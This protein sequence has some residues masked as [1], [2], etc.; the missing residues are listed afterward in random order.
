MDLEKT[1]D[2]FKNNFLGRGVLWVLSQF[3]SLG[4]AL[5]KFLYT[6]HWRKTYSV[7]TRV[8]CI[9][10]ITAGGTG[11]TT[12]VLLAARTL[13]QAGI[14]TAIISRGYKRA[15][16]DKN[17]VVLFDDELENNWTTA[18]DEPFMMSRSLADVKVPI[19]IHKDRYLAATEALRRF[20]SQIILLDDGFQHFRLKRDVDIV[21]IDARNP[22]GD[23]RLLPYGTLRENLKGLSRANLILITH[24]D[25]VDARRLEDIRDQIR[26]INEDVQILS[27]VHKPDHYFDICESKKVPLTALKGEAGAFSAIGEPGG[28]EDTLRKLGLTL[29][30][31]WRY[32][33]HRR[34]T[35]FDLKNFMELSGGAPLITT[36]KDFVKF[37]DNWRDI[38]NKNVYVLSINMEIKG[39]KEFEVFTEALYPNFTKLAGGK[40]KK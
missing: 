10:N 23:K 19:V 17:P 32:P 9:G 24:S 26:L 1:R 34:Y 15:V 33:D 22:F 16:K 37:P 13:A 29:T 31:V 25:H 5:N 39:K 4:A 27:A 36:F 21:L 14:R 6:H 38:L 40:S 12:A 7:N 18:G 8:V 2:A 11:K 35:D 30:K 20:K 28:F 3:Y